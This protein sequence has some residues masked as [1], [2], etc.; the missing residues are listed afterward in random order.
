[1]EANGAFSHQ[2]Y[3]SWTTL[4]TLMARTPNS[5]IEKEKCLL[6]YNF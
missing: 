2:S 6:P 4:E 1:M 3:T 5:A